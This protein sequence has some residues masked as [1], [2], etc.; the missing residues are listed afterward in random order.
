M[1]WSVSALVPDRRVLGI[2]SLNS[3]P[4][5]ST[6]EH[7]ARATSPHHCRSLSVLDTVPSPIRLAIP[8][9]DIPFCLRSTNFCRSKTLLGR[10]GA[11]FIPE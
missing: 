2:R 5:L 6:N 8:R 7:S 3:S 10:C 1:V 11:L 4:R 9:S